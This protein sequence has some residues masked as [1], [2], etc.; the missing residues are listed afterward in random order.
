MDVVQGI[1]SASFP[2]ITLI[3]SAPALPV[4]PLSPSDV[5]T[6]LV[7]SNAVLKD[8]ASYNSHLIHLILVDDGVYSFE[9]SSAV[10]EYFNTK[11]L[12]VAFSTV[13]S[14][15]LKRPLNDFF[16]FDVPTL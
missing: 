7:W 16:D 9:Y 8:P 3:A 15:I 4:F 14:Y 1:I 10:D 13:V 11:S 6:T 5:T 12:S 2:S